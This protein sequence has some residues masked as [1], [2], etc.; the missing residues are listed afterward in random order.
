[1]AKPTRQ[2]TISR[3]FFVTSSTWE[4]RALFQSERMAKLF[5]DVLLHYREEGRFLL[6]EFTLLPDH[7][8]LLLT[9]DSGISLERAMQFIKGGYSFRAAKELGFKGEVWQR[10]FTDHRVRE[11]RDFEAH[12]Q[13][14]WQNAVKRGL[15]LKPEEYPYC[16]AFPGLPL[17]GP[18]VNLRG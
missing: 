14:I 12:R 5:V 6:H 16:S 4:R 1:M 15:A 10:G 2:T 18:P 11:A 7:F 8:H 3:T 9:P 13:Y 17:D